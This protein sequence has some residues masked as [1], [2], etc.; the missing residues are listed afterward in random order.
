[1]GLQ[2]AQIKEYQI[3]EGKMVCR[4][5]KMAPKT[6]SWESDQRRETRRRPPAIDMSFHYMSTFLATS[7]EDDRPAF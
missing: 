3:L 1:M 6:R 4:Y 7:Y 2:R 5:L